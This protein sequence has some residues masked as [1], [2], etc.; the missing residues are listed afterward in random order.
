MKES[1]AGKAS[2]VSGYFQAGQFS[3]EDWNFGRTL[4]VFN[5][6][7]R[8]RPHVLPMG[9]YGL[10]SGADVGCVEGPTP[11]AHPW[12]VYFVWWG[13]PRGNLVRCL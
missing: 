4:G 10:K 2:V 12:S 8:A 5:T 1:F 9:K 6:L 7:T 3:A 11:G 13:L